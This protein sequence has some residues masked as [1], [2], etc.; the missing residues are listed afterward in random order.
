MKDTATAANR[1]G[2][3]NL[4]LLD[5]SGDFSER[6][7][8]YPFALEELLCRYVGEGGPPMIHIWRHPRA[9]V[10]GLRDSRLPQAAAAG[11][12]LEADGYSVAVR[13]SGGAAVPLDLGVVNVSLIGRKRSGA[14]DF[15]DDFERMYELIA[16]ALEQ[17]DGGVSKGEIAG[18]YCPGDFDLSIGGRKFCGIAQRRQQHG[19]VVQA[20]IVAEG[21]GAQKAGIA[22][23]FY[24]QAAE[25]AA[26]DTVY[27]HVSDS[28][29]ASLSELLGP[30][31]GLG[32]HGQPA[33]E[34]E[35]DSAAGGLAGAAQ[36][37]IDAIKR[38]VR[39]RQTPEGLAEASARL[40]LPDPTE[41][42]AMVQRMRER[43]GF[44]Q[45]AL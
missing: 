41:V 35:S 8:L 20:F 23:L 19:Y 13:N 31:F 25:G 5:R 45:E 30:G 17:A 15:H 40:W 29:M 24:E 34:A 22:R 1:E 39:E 11:R 4:L 28:S 37:F 12:S 38:V 44:S 6:D 18:A 26:A 10:M 43:Y 7:I 36:A 33:A 32:V 14:I 9:F 16:L 3:Q 21:S 2:L 42:R 27:P